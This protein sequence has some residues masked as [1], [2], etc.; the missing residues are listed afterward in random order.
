MYTKIYYIHLYK[1][2]KVS[3]KSETT[4]SATQSVD[5]DNP[6]INNKVDRGHQRVGYEIVNEGAPAQF[7]LGRLRRRHVAVYLI[8][9]IGVARVGHRRFCPSYLVPEVLSRG[10]LVV[11]QSQG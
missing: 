8:A 3:Y 10:S 4:Q 7:V 9:T 11:A 6:V 5:L 2:K 1:Y